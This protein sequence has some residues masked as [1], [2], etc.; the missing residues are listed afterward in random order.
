MLCSWFL[1]KLYDSSMWVMTFLVLAITSYKF[2]VSGWRKRVRQQRMKALQ[3]LLSQG[4]DLERSIPTNSQHERITE[5]ERSVTAWIN[6]TS[7]TLGSYSPQAAVAFNQTGNPTPLYL[8]GH[9]A[10]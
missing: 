7:N 9:M 6:E 2:V 10:L 5:W 8:H 1:M 3:I 4:V